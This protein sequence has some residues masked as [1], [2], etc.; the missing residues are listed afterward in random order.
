MRKE[1]FLC[2]FDQEWN[3]LFVYID[4]I[5]TFGIIYEFAR[6]NVTKTVMSS[7]LPPK[8]LSPLRFAL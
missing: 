2:I 4:T 6:T 8:R 1:V 3:F 7:I 5:A